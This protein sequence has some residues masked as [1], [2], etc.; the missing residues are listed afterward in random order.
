VE[1]LVKAFERLEDFRGESFGRQVGRIEE[2]F[3]GARND[4]VL[5]TEHAIRFFEGGRSIRQI[6]D[7]NAKLGTHFR[8][9]YGEQFRLVRDYYQLK[10]DLVQVKDVSPLLQP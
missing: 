2:L 6:L 9:R 3:A 4:Y 7:G 1:G 8:T 5:G 10:K